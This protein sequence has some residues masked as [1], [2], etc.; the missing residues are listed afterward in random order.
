[1]PHA[2]DDVRLSTSP[3]EHRPQNT[4]NSDES[5]AASQRSLMWLF[6]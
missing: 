2:N 5:I 3:D 6:S 4:Q 1:M